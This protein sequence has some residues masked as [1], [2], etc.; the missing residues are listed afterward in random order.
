MNESNFKEN[1]VTD[2]LIFD[3]DVY[4]ISKNRKKIIGR[5]Q[6]HFIIDPSVRTIQSYHL[7]FAVEE[8]KNKKISNTDDCLTLVELHKVLMK[9]LKSW[10]LYL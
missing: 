10:P 9:V 4:V 6:L 3:L 5:P 2:R 8:E 1:N 7:S